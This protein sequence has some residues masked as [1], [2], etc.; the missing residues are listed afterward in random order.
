MKLAQYNLEEADVSGIQANSFGFQMNA[1]MYSIMIDKLYKNKPGAVIRELSCNAYDSHVLAGKEDVPFEIHMPSWLD[2]TFHIRDFG[3]GI[4]HEAFE[5]IYT[6]VGASTKEDSNDQI[7]AYG[8]GSKTAFTMSDT[9][10]VENWHGGIKTTWACFKSAGFPQV[11]EVGREPSDEPSGLKVSFAFTSDAV[12]EFKK[13]LPRQLKFF[14]VKPTLTG[15]SSANYEWPK[16]PDY[17]GKK[18][19]YY[20]GNQGYNREA[21]VLMGNVNYRFTPED[22]GVDR[23]GTY[24]EYYRL[25]EKPLCIVANL[26]D[27]DIPPSRETLEI[28]DKTKE[29]ILSVLETVRKTYEKEYVDGLNKCLTLKEAMIYQSNANTDLLSY[30][31]DSEVTYDQGKT[32]VEYGTLKRNWYTMPEA[33]LWNYTYSTKYNYQQ[34]TGVNMSLIQDPKLSFYV[35]DLGR[36]GRG[37]LRDNYHTIP[38]YRMAHIF[39]PSSSVKPDIIKAECDKLIADVKVKH[40]YVVKLLSSVIGFPVIAARVK[41]KA[42][43]TDQVYKAKKSLGSVDKLHGY[44]AEYTEDDFPT[45]GYFIEIHGSNIVTSESLWDTW[46]NIAYALKTTTE[47]IYFVRSK[48]IPKLD[49]K[50]V[51][52]IQTLFD[53]MKA[54]AKE[55]YVQALRREAIDQVFWPMKINFLSQCPLVIRDIPELR[56]ALRFH[57]RLN[58]TV[59]INVQEA[60]Q[61]YMRLAGAVKADLI[62]KP[63]I[64]YLKRLEKMVALQDQFKGITEGV[65]YIYNTSLKEDLYRGINKLLENVV[66]VV[67]IVPTVNNR[68]QGA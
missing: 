31:L 46:N 49:Q 39:R 62:K 66:S 28:T 53:T 10:I 5:E 37:H 18:Y 42:V 35:D 21:S 23:W 6:N 60:R 7:G 2:K 11:S 34:T 32:K 44:K 20:D 59:R 26:G 15:D 47:N 17:T 56:T 1:K 36:G 64:P 27:V 45:D 30:N 63:V 24:S 41:G 68:T 13:E 65:D 25:F 3:T 57:T 16:I 52:P 38:E 33:P 54:T 50:K 61:E 8:L 43:P 4:P 29:Y 58:K 9:F 12:D 19:F 55:R 48:S 40:G 14:P 51:L 22:I 67:P